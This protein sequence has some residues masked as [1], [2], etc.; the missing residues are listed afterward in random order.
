MMKAIVFQK[1]GTFYSKKLGYYLDCWVLSKNL[2]K[3]NLFKTDFGWI[4]QRMRNVAEHG[5]I[6]LVSQIYKIHKY[7]MS[8][9]SCFWSLS[10]KPNP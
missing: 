6:F 10:K 8:K 2:K 7:F 5:I 3:E 9:L 4:E 1:G